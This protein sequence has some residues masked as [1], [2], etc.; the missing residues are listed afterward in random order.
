MHVPEG[1][2]RR[3]HGQERDAADGRALDAAYRVRVRCHRRSPLSEREAGGEGEGVCDWFG[4]PLGHTLWY[5][6]GLASTA[7]TLSEGS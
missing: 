4:S 3:D 1:D 5:V 7:T 6:L 2:D